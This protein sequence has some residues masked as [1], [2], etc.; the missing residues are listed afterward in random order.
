MISADTTL[1]S[2]M[3]Y[4]NL[5]INSTKILSPN[6]YKIFV[7]GTLTNNGT[8]RRNGNAGGAGGN[9]SI[10]VVGAAGAAAAALNAGTLED[11]VAGGAGGI[12]VTSTS[13]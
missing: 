9:A 7:K 2:D 6:G 5:T 1:T 8:I 12:G 11:S 3:F 10:G 4:N 13:Q